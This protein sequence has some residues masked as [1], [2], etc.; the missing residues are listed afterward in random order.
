MSQPSI[1]RAGSL[2]STSS[3]SSVSDTNVDTDVDSLTAPSKPPEVKRTRKRFSQEQL[4]LLEHAYHKASHPT[5]EEREE[6]ARQAD[7]YVVRF[8][9]IP[10]RS[11]NVVLG[12]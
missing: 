4:I 10:V 1:S 5:R 3:F 7:M 2:S 6:I 8:I 9:T 11:S 12:A